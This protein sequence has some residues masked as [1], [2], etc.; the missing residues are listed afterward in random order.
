MN[1]TRDTQPK[2]RHN[3]S[4]GSDSMRERGFTLVELTV[5]MVAFAAIMIVAFGI[6]SQLNR[7]GMGNETLARTQSAARAASDQIEKDL[8]AAG[9]GV[10]FSRGQQRFVY[11]DAYQIAFNA[12]LL[13]NVDPDGTAIPSAVRAGSVPA[14]LAALHT[15]SQSFNTGAETIVYTLDS[16]SDGAVAAE[17]AVDDGA[18]DNDNPRDMMLYRRVFGWN[19]NANTMEERQIA[20]V[21]GPGPNSDG[22]VP[23]PLFSYLIDADDDRLT[24]PTL[25]G[26]TNGNGE[27]EA[28][29]IVSLTPLSQA[30]MAR[31]E[32]IT[33]TVTGETDRPDAKTSDN[34]GFR[35][36]ELRSEVLVRHAPRTSAIVYG[37]VFQ[38]TDGDQVRDPN[39]SGIA[40]VLVRSSA[41]MATQTDATGKYRLVLSPGYQTISETDP[42]GFMSS[43]PNTFN[44][45]VIPGGYHQINFGDRSPN[46]SG[47]VKGIVFDDVNENGA[48]EGDELGIPGVVVYADGGEQATTD[49][50]GAYVLTVPVGNRTI[51]ETDQEGYSSTTP[52]SVD[53]L[54]DTDGQV[55]TVM[56]GDHMLAESGTIEGYVYLDDNGNGVMDNFEGGVQGAMVYAEVDS[57]E[58]N[59]S[60][61]F[62]MTVPAGHYNVWE[63]DPPG[64]TSSTPNLYR[65]VRV[66]VDQTVTL[67]FGDIVQE[68]VDFDVITL[69]D[70]ERAL[71]LAS[72]NLHEDNKGDPD[73]VLGTRSSGGS[74]NM[75]IWHNA[76]RNQNTPNGSLFSATPSETRNAGRDIMS[77]TYVENDGPDDGL[78]VLGLRGEGT[79]DIS[80]WSVNGGQPDNAPNYWYATIGGES[81][82]DLIPVN[83]YGTSSTDYLVGVKTSPQTGSVELWSGQG[84]GELL[85]VPGGTITVDASGLGM[86]LGEAAAVA[87]GD[88]NGD[89]LSD[90][91]VGTIQMVGM[92]AVDV[93]LRLPDNGGVYFKPHQYFPVQGEITDIL[94]TEMF[95]DNSS[96][97]DIVVAAKTSDISG[98]IELWVQHEDGR[99]GILNE[100]FRSFDDYMYTEGAPIVVY[101]YPMDNDMF[102]DLLIGTRTSSIYQGDFELARTFGYLPAHATPITNTSLGAVV[103][104]TLNDF[105]M[106][107]A[108]DLAVG[109]QNSATEGQVVIF[110]R[111]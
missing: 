2:A 67:Y 20:L 1:S 86:P 84:N 6:M 58:A 85:R 63:I 36:V 11:A 10:D 105:N 47:T 83:V 55:E 100:G 70:T 68:D 54:I 72:G 93:Y 107:N 37:T 15:P 32:R 38:D 102:P 101:A 64:Y 25:H 35:S 40:G 41:G 96:R 16:G 80:V 79:P 60:G 29:E 87:M 43:T 27:L 82:L 65:N 18:E 19:G 42:A 13:P 103:T 33:I 110:F 30:E 45:D 109:T 73:L 99:F 26:D 14:Q 91:V 48:M 111:Q 22:Q 78:L 9:V 89:G 5:T 39:E 24:A 74:N 106:D 97:P 52:N 7:A 104:M 62:S 76:R 108:M 21:R 90:L 12:N 81:V 34:D 75:L 51:S 49:A 53:I 59:L 88:L 23:P 66:D 4:I 69:A 28:G 3:L 57:A 46:G 77:M 71:S 61:Y 8:R 17:D 31:L 94:V 92:S 98:G 44:V 95:D 50:L 56:F